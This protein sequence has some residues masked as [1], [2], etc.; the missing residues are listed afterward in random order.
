MYAISRFLF[1]FIQIRHWSKPN[2]CIS[3]AYYTVL[4]PLLSLLY[5]YFVF[6]CISA[7]LHD[8]LMT[9]IDCTCKPVCL[10][11]NKKKIIIINIIVLHS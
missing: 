10:H 6:Y 8:S 3:A 5:K 11:Y 4:N 9:A 1:V 7:V 2:A